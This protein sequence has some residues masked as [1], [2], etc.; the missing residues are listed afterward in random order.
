[1]YEVDDRDRIIEL[2]QVLQSN[3]GAPIPHV[4]AAEHTVLPAY[5]LKDEPPNSVE[6]W[7]RAIRPTGTDEA[8]AIVRFAMCVAHMFGPPNDEAFAGH[9]VAF[10]LTA[11]SGSSTL[12]GYADSSA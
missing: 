8:I 5:Y 1:M 7:F 2:K 4:L 11:R 9:R 6:V 12:P 10:T 3:A